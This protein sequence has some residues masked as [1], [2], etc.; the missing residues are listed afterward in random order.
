MTY[1]CDKCGNPGLYMVG[2]IETGE[3]R[4]L[5]GNCYGDPAAQTTGAPDGRIITFPE[6]CEMCDIEPCVVVVTAR[7][8]GSSMGLGDRCRLVMERAAWLGQSDEIRETLRPFVEQFVSAAGDDKP[9][10]GRR[11]AGVA[12][13]GDGHSREALAPPAGEPAAVS[14]TADASPAEGSTSTG[15]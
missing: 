12:V 3:Q 1:N 9:K 13:G 8:D 14:D 11:S 6:N 10:R 2:N 15:A 7:Y 4:V 5:C